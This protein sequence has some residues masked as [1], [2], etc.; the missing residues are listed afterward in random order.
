MMA[1]VP[2]WLLTDGFWKGVAT[3]GLLS[4]AFFCWLFH[5]MRPR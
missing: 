1:S 5:R 3:T 4:A 2:D